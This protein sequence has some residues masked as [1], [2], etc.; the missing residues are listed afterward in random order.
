M[1]TINGARALGLDHRIGSL[2]PGKLADLIAVDLSQPETQPLYHPLSQLVYSCN[3]SQVTHSWIGGVQVM[4]GRQL[5]Q[6]DLSALAART[7]VWQERISD[8]MFND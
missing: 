3:G 6:I 1:A 2:E 5:T 8:G 4:S 7:R